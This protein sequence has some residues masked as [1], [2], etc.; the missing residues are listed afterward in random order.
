MA[1][2]LALFLRRDHAP[3]PF[4]NL[5]VPAPPAVGSSAGQYG[6]CP[7]G[8]MLAGATTSMLFHDSCC[9]VFA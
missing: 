8:G 3:I 9:I 1:V 2:V 6:S 5:D 4:I 7:P